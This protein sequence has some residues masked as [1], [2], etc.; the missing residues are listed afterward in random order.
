MGV[1]LTG[2]VSLRDTERG[3]EREVERVRKTITAIVIREG[4]F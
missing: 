1:D 3:R 2:A 4:V